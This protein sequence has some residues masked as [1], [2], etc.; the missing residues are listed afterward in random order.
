LIYHRRYVE[1]HLNVKCKVHKMPYRHRHP[2]TVHIY[3]KQFLYMR[4]WLINKNVES[5]KMINNRFLLDNDDNAKIVI[6]I[7]YFNLKS[8]DCANMVL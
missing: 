3:T 4:N 2:K 8:F 1:L 7:H 5:P 6:N